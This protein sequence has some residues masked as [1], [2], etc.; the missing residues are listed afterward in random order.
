MNIRKYIGGIRYQG[1]GKGIFFL[2]E[3][4]IGVRNFKRII[5]ILRNLYQREGFRIDK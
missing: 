3:I 2:W 4:F 5:E 1:K